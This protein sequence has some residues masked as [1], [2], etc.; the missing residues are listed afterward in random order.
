LLTFF[1]KK[2]LNSVQYY[3]YLPKITENLLLDHNLLLNGG[4][5]KYNSISVPVC[6]LIWKY[7]NGSDAML[8]L[9]MMVWVPL[10]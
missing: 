5:K 6:V 8:L 2:I 3:K 1:K 7:A 4:V 10:I 9:L